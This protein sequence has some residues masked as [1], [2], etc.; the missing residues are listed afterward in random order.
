MKA[1]WIVK[2]ILLCGGVSQRENLDKE[3]NNVNQADR[4]VIKLC[5]GVSSLGEEHDESFV[6]LLESSAVVYR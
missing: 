5:R 3:L 2:I 4:A 1:L 6:E